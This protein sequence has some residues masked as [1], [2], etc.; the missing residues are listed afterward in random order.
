[1]KLYFYT[2]KNDEFRFHGIKGKFGWVSEENKVDRERV[3]KVEKKLLNFKFLIKLS[4]IF[5][6]LKSFIFMSVKIEL[7][8]LQIFRKIALIHNYYFCNNNLTI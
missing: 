4:P 7:Q 3:N 5:H 6:F 8:N 2:I 1:M